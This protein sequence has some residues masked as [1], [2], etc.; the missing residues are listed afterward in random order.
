MTSANMQEN[1]HWTMK[2]RTH[3]V[4]HILLGALGMAAAAGAWTFSVTREAK[5]ATWVMKYN[6]TVTY[7]QTHSLPRTGY[8]TVLFGCKFPD[9]STDNFWNGDIQYDTV[10][11]HLKTIE[12]AYLSGKLLAIEYSPDSDQQKWGAKK[13]DLLSISD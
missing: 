10:Q 13:F 12:A 3:I 6:C 7:V 9:N 2:L 8:P 4:R 5:A 1:V 11:V